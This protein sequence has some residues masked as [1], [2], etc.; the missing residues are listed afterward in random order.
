[1]ILTPIAAAELPAILAA[2][3]KGLAGD[4]FAL[5]VFRRIAGTLALAPDLKTDL[6]AGREKAVTLARRLGIGVLDED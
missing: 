2:F 4:A 1:M 6:H 3:E 5:A